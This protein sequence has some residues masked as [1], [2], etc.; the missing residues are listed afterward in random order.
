MNECA[1]ALQT[2]FCG[3]GSAASGQAEANDEINEIAGLDQ[4]P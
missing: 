3:A 2:A 1:A 4:R